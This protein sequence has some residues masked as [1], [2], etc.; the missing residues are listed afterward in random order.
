VHK[1]LS[2]VVI[3]TIL[4][5]SGV[6]LSHVFNHHKHDVCSNDNDSDTH[7]H[8]FDLDC[9]FYKFKLNTN[10]YND[11]YAYKVLIQNE[12]SKINTCSYNFLRTH[13]QDTAYLR[14]PPT[15]A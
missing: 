2:V 9:E 12:F 13:K 3:L 10:Y 5:P 4:L 6:K 1:I 11:F 15:L 8:E 7:F 14:G